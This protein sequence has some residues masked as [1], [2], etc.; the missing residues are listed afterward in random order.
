MLYRICAGRLYILWKLFLNLGILW[1]KSLKTVSE[2]FQKAL[3][4]T[5]RESDVLEHTLLFPCACQI[6]HEDIHHFLSVMRSRGNSELF[7]ALWYRW[8]INRLHVM[9]IFIHQDIRQTRC[10]VWISNLRIEMSFYRYFVVFNGQDSK[11][12][13]YKNWD[14]VTWSV[15]NRQSQLHEPIS[16]VSHIFLVFLPQEL[17]FFRLYDLPIHFS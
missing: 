15:Q 2:W 14:D 6:L 4:E 9:P 12:R 13:T 10:Y 3:D 11:C 16:K 5:V 7:L 17:S 1:G 8:I